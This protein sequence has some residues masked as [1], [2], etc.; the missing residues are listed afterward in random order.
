V[1]AFLASRAPP[2]DNAAPLY[3][4]ALALISSD[5]GGATAAPLEKEIAELA[6]LEKLAAGSVPPQQI[7]QLLAKAAPALAQIDAAQ[8]KP[9]CVFQ[10]GLTLDALLPHAQAARTFG[11]VSLLQIQQARPIGNFPIA[12]AAVGRSLRLSRDLQPRGPVVCQLVSIALDGMILSAVERIVLGSPEL[13]SADCDR[14]LAVLMRHKQQMLNR[15]EEGLKL[16]YI[17]SRNSIQDLQS[18]RLTIQQLV[19][20]GGT[21]PGLPA[22]T[23]QTPVFN[24]E[25]EILACNN[26]FRMMLA[27]AASAT[28]READFAKVSQEFARQK[29]EIERFKAATAAAPLGERAK[30][31]AQA[32]AFLCLLLAPGVEAFQNSDRRVAAQLAG[33]QMLLALRRYEIAHGSLPMDLQ[34][35]AAESALK[36]VPIDPYD[37]APLRFAMVVG[38]PTVYS[39]GK[40]LKDDGGQ[41]DWKFGQQPGDYLFVLPPRSP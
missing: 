6:N 14:L 7:D 20:L 29:T 3:M 5:L 31:Q 8:A 32:P 1:K 4:T 39:V 24:W 25:A 22:S 37:G 23:S 35:A 30:L 12:E 17:M 33:T 16:E 18:G 10:T 21:D 27:E 36:T 11:R 41:A 9:K 28:A 34:T 40:D 13:K 15:T 19:A 2:A 26:V 38:Q